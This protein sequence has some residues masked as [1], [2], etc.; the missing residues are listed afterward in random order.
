DEEAEWKELIEATMKKK[1]AT[2]E[3]DMDDRLEKQKKKTQS[4]FMKQ[5]TDLAQQAV[6]LPPPAEPAA[7]ETKQPVNAPFFNF[8]FI[9]ILIVY[10]KEPG[11]PPSSSHTANRL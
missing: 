6:E 10:S 5:L 8:Y 7:D 9:I 2:G 3:E 1:L 11:A 4:D